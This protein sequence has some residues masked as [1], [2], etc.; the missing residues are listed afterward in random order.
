MASMPTL[1][2]SHGGPDIVINESAARDYLEILSEHLP[3]PRA[4]VI[5]S[6]HFETDGVAVV[7]DPAPGM[8]Y[9][10]GGFAPELYEM[11]YPAPGEPQLAERVFAM[12]DEAG[13]EPS[14]IARRGYDHGTWTPLRLAF[15]QADIPVVQVSVD[16]SRDAAWHY[17]LGRALAPLREEGVLLIGSGHITH[18][19]RELFPVMRGG[20]QADPE[21]AA[22]VDAFV[23]WFADK[24]AAGDR[25]A[26]LDWRAQ[27]PF[28][29]EN[30]PTDEHLMPIFFA[31]GAAGEAPRAERTHASRQLGFFAY[32][33]YLFH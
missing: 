28:A 30:H 8:I 5:V 24:L 33:S 15:P 4:I 19:L 9:D 20:K 6:A 13:L 18:N 16:P 29:Q 27:A 21:L 10:F 11:V 22:H 12:L 3:R 7:T 2:I 32:D 25:D 26:L 31:Y 17:A 23:G 1:F 14:R